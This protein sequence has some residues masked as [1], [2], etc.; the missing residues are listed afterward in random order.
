MY[1][2]TGLII[3]MNFVING[4]SCLKWKKKKPNTFDDEDS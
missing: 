4:V 3:I 1:N 2:F